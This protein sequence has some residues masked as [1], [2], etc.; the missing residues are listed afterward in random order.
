MRSAHVKEL[1]SHFGYKLNVDGIDKVALSAEK[2]DRLQNGEIVF[3]F[4]DV[5]RLL[6]RIAGSNQILLFNLENTRTKI[7][8]ISFGARFICSTNCL[9][10]CLKIN[11]RTTSL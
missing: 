4:S 2:R 7:R 6:K 1:A 5:P 10:S 11:G 9:K 3:Q 8:T